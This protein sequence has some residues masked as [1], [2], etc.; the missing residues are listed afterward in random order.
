LAKIAAE[1]NEALARRREHGTPG[2][3][4]SRVIA[5]AQG[6]IVADVL[7][8]HGPRDRPY[9]ERHTHPTIAMVLAGSFQ[10][11]CPAGYSVMT[12]GSLMLGNADRCFL[13]SHQHGD[14]DRCISFWYEPDYFARLAADAGARGRNAGF[15]VSAL[16]AVRPLSSLIARASAGALGARD[17]PWDELA[18]NLAVRTLQLTAGTSRD[19]RALP[20]NAEA[21]VSRTVRAIDRYPGAPLTL[22]T[23]S[24]EAGLSPYHYLRTFERVTGLTPHQYVRR[25]RLRYAATRLLTEPGKVLDIALDCGF[26]DVSNF[27]RAFREEFGVSPRGFRNT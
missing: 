27:N 14:G 24:T 5:Q 15:S 16:P 4:M 12:P 23:L 8:T 13:C 26:G 1:L 10:Y 3:T 6:W 17:V 18:V 7:C 22:D 2:R 25:A 11:R 20:V 9:E 19:Q 21:R